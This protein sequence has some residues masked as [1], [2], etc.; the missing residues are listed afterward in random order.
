[1]AKDEKKK[2][3]ILGLLLFA[4]G[5]FILLS[6]IS[7]NPN[8]IPENIWGLGYSGNLMGILGLYIAH[9]LIRGFLGV[10]SIYI[11][12]MIMMAGINQFRVYFKNLFRITTICTIISVFGVTLIA[13]FTIN[14]EN[15]Q[16]TRYAG[17]VGQ[18][19][20][21]VLFK[22]L[23]PTGGILIYLLLLGITLLVLTRMSITQLIQTVE[24]FFKVL[25]NI[26]KRRFSGWQEE[27][28]EKK[29]V[30]VKAP[31]EKPK[32]STPVVR[33]VVPELSN[34]DNSSLFPASGGIN[35]EEKLNGAPSPRPIIEINPLLDPLNSRKTTTNGDYQ[36][37]GADLFK[38][39]EAQ[40]FELTWEELDNQ[41]RI[42]EDTLEDFGI[43][44]KIVKI[45]PGPVITRF[46][47]EPAPGIKVSKF[48]SL[49]DDLARVMR[50]QRIRVVAPIPGKASIGIEIPNP[51]PQTVFF[52]EV[53]NSPKFQDAKS[54][55]SIILGKTI[56]GAI[57]VTDLGAMP[58]LLIAGSTGSG[59]SVCINAIITSILFKAHPKEV[60]FVMIDPKRL[61]LAPYRSLKHHHLAFREDLNEEV[62]TTAN[63]A[64][65][66]LKSMVLEMERRY[67]L[68]A[69]GGVRKLE[70]FNTKLK[71][72]KIQFSDETIAISEPLPYIVLVIDELADLMLTAAKEVEEPIARLTQ[73][74]RAVG[75]HLIVATQRP[76]VDVITGVIK[77][78]FPC[79]I[80]FYVASK[81]DSRTILDMNGAEKLLGKGDMLFLPP[82]TPEP[83]RVH[84][85]YLS[86]EDVDHIVEHIEAQP[87]YPKY[88][89]PI[90][91]DDESY[92]SNFDGDYAHD[93]YFNDAAK[94]VVQ[95]GVGSASMLQRRLKIGHARAGRLIDALEV[96]GIVGPYDGSK[97][98]HVL[99]SEQDLVERGIF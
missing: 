71:E 28:E 19:I 12:I 37:P 4:F 13:M 46:E 42:L 17:K 92:L 26:L 23:N 88:D 7:Y 96:A 94:I 24:N 93:K 38:P 75:I 60:K 84:G 95:A 1:M 20:V 49:A 18:I 53:I 33:P 81:T 77:A 79:R 67:E 59:K 15:N 41:A 22:F 2:G 30:K 31:I 34:T 97:A 86:T 82:G 32:I 10:F 44:G 8:D 6:I 99:V 25:G 43:E 40:D 14:L 78:N 51:K 55:L 50:A 29:A 76:S 16:V 39:V 35:E 45:N 63:N 11:P 64:I 98:R 3:E 47:V 54:P 57:Y 66:I 9:L 90:E 5:L 48:T 56:D 85:S 65:S 80:G 87:H 74:S 62:V 91:E 36:F 68:L 27:R 58:H 83:V 72:G 89:L 70:D 21:Q 73:M 61:E 52:A 69:Q